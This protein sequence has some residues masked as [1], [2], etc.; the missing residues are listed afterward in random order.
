VLHKFLV[1]DVIVPDNRAAVMDQSFLCANQ[2]VVCIKFLEKTVVKEKI[3]GQCLIT[4][5]QCFFERV[6]WCLAR[7]KSTVKSANDQV[8]DGM[9]ENFLTLLDQVIDSLTDHALQLR[10]K[11]KL[12]EIGMNSFYSLDNS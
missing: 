8:V 5:R 12:L 10:L 4:M 2:I 3:I 11:S 9:P 6:L 1:F 7:L